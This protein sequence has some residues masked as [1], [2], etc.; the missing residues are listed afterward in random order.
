MSENIKILVD[1]AFLVVDVLGRFGAKP[2]A[3]AALR[4]ANT[5]DLSTR[6]RRKARLVRDGDFMVYRVLGRYGTRAEAEAALRSRKPVAEP[7]APVPIDECDARVPDVECDAAALRARE[8]FSYD[9][10]S[11]EL[12]RKSDGALVSREDPTG[13]AVVWFA[14]K[15]WSPVRLA[16]LLFYGGVPADKWVMPRRKAAGSHTCIRNLY[17]K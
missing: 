3:M 15:A 4:L 14:G 8:L 1:D 2:E 13:L 7:V 11:G 9:S 10:A 5:R 6:K 16:W 12:R 17:L